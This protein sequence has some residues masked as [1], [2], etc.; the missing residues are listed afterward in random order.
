[1]Q[2][3]RLLLKRGVSARQKVI[4][5]PPPSSAELPMPELKPS[6]QML[7]AQ[8][9]REHIQ[10]CYAEWK[11]R[12]KPFNMLRFFFGQGASLVRELADGTTHTALY[13]RYIQGGQIPAETPYSSFAENIVR[14]RKF[15]GLPPRYK[16]RSENVT[17]PPP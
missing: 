2:A 12:P 3:R 13:R 11:A 16:P 14:F 8:A 15:H 1:M 7:A 17:D 10:R 5:M 6:S 4:I 9:L